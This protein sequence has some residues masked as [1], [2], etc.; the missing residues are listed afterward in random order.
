M[1]SP[2][3]SAVHTQP[4]AS[5]PPADLSMQEKENLRA[6]FRRERIFRT[7]SYFSPIVILFL[8]EIS[9]QLGAIDRRFFPP[10]SAI[11]E[12]FL[13]MIV[14]LELFR[15]IGATLQRVA[16]GFLMGAI[17]GLF[18]GVCLGLFLRPRQ[19]VGPILAALY[20]VP[21]IAILPLIL[22]IFGT[23]D[24]SKYVIIAIGVFFMMYYNTF[25]GVRQVPQIYLDVAKSTG[26]NRFQVFTQIALPSALPQ[27]FTGLK[28]SA[29]TSY[30][31]I[32]A[33]EFLG[34]RN[35][36]GF[37]IW[38]SWQTFSVTR[39]FVGIVTISLLGYLTL[40]LI[41]MIERRVVPW[42]RN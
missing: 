25:G 13:S 39:M 11:A 22:L 29:G 18:A 41:D 8:W 10:P 2:A 28:L 21:K 1:N 9:A 16:I 26:A 6:P 32:A 31:I 37:F 17:P 3:P 24:M 20:P 40:T 12:T 5:A 19:I 38:A 7:L 36:V 15:H 4:A 35:G 34:A 33:A 27:I 14:S 23:G 42:A 30:I